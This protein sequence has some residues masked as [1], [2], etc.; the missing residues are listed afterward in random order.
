MENIKKR[1]AKNFIFNTLYNAMGVLFPLITV[2]YLSR[3]LQADGLGRVSYATNIVSW[4]ILFASLGIPRYGV[5]EI[6]KGRNKDINIVFSELFFINLISTTILSIIYIL[7]IFNIMYFKENIV[8]YLVLGIQLFLNIFNV[9]WFYQGIEDFQYIT[10]RSFI[11]KLISLFLMFAFV[12]N[13][14]DYIIYGLLQSLAVAGNYLFNFIHIRKFCK[15]ENRSLSFSRHIKPIFV[16]TA[17]QLAISIYGLLDI[18]ML[19]AMCNN[20]T[21]GYYTNV[22]K[23]MYTIATITASLGGALLPELV[24]SYNSRDILRVKR[25]SEKS[26]NFII[27]LTFPISVGVIFISQDLVYILFGREFSP[28]IKT[29]QIYAPFI[30]FSTIGN[31]FGTQ[32]LMTFNEEQKLLNTTLIG[33]ITDFIL[34]LFM[35][36][37]FAQNGATFSSVIAELLV[38]AFQIYYVEKICKIEI[39]KSNLLSTISSTLLMILSL[40]IILN[41]M[42][43]SLL[44]LVVS[45]ALGMITYFIACIITKNEFVMMIKRIIIKKHVKADIR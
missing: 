9:D 24:S 17:T 5:R 32:L 45:V 38:T 10:V 11:I 3:V 36:K 6:A 34:N 42:S 18:T 43:S 22:Q 16:L 26:L 12:K 4:F 27:S 31:L 28:A 35:I 41:V 15:I 2:P 33:A 29:L 39:D 14:D 20:K 37:I 40:I 13:H 44:R 23:L 8:L 25:I 21:V 19:G 1:L 30:V 7:C